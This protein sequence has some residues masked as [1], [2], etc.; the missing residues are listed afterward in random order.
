MGARGPRRA[1]RV[2]ACAPLLLLA[3]AAF[4]QVPGDATVREGDD[5]E[6]PCAFRAG[7]A[8]SRS[9]EIQWW[10]LQRDPPARAKVA[11]KDATKISTVRVQGN[12]ISHRLRLSGVRLQDEGVYECRVSDYGDTETHEH[13]AQALLRVLA[14]F[15]PPDVQAA[16]AASHIQR[17]T[18]PRRHGPAAHPT[19]PH[20]PAARPTPPHGP[21]KRPDLGAATTTAITAASGSPPPG[22]AAILRQQHRAGT[23]AVSAADPLLCTSLL[24]LHRLVQLLLN[25]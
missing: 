7:G 23:G 11:T 10:Y 19:P 21:A 16:E 4:T 12:D 22:Q 2:L 18:A 6:L 5:V 3:H 8:A 13:R 17:G 14:R 24:V 9:L 25:H 20:G 15:T 1:L